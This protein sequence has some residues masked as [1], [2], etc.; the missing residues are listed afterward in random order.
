VAA[1][2]TAAA[3]LTSLVNTTYDRA[4]RA[5]PRVSTA[6]LSAA[7][8]ADGWTARHLTHHFHAVSDEVRRAAVA[9]LRISPGRIT[10]IE[11]G[12]DP[13]RVGAP[14]PERRRR[15]RAALGLSEA[16]EVVVNV[17]RQEFQKGQRHLVEAVG[18]LPERSHLVLLQA[19]R[20][21]RVSAELRDLAERSAAAKRIRFLGERDDVPE[22]LA[23]ADVFA[24]PSLYEGQ[25]GA[26]IEAMA[27]GLPI[28][29]ADIPAL[30]DMV[31]P[32]GNA[33][34]VR[35]E[36]AGALAGGISELLDDPRRREEFAARSRAIFVE[37]FGL[38]R[39]AERFVALYERVIAAR[40]SP[41]SRA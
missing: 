9:A 13:G 30:R 5:D 41:D 37:R 32:D 15:A 8:L 19:G 39:S 1:V 31:E 22:V 33:V 12:R 38:E 21:G 6:K 36:D 40:R 18:R 14:S 24:F 10:V 3:V 7:R 25:S 26:V 35:P 27:L 34:L 17:G 29:A 2:R 4:R 23:A 20:T 16:D 11:R 28:V